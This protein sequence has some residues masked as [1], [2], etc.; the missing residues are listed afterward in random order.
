MLM[1]EILK[2]TMEDFFGED[3]HGR[4]FSIAVNANC[5][6]HRKYLDEDETTFCHQT[7]FCCSKFSI[8]LFKAKK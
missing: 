1:M 2:T 5:W 8:P 7:T 3:V 4:N 6:M